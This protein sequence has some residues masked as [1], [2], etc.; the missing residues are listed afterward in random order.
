MTTSSQLKQPQVT[1]V[2][3]YPLLQYGWKNS[4]ATLNL[5]RT[6]PELCGFYQVNIF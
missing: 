1:T 4:P 5:V 2:L 3:E 6:N